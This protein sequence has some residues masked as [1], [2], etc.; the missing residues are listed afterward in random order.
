MRSAVLCHSTEDAALS[1]ELAGFLEL[2]CP[3]TVFQEEGLIRADYGLLDAV[4]RGLSAGVALVLL[5][6]DSVPNV[7]PPRE[8]W[9]PILLKQ[10]Y[11]FGSEI[12]CLLAR[13]CKFPALLRRGRNFFDLSQDRL[14]GRRALKRWLLGRDLLFQRAVELPEEGHPAGTDGEL[15]EKLRRHLAD[16]PGLESDIGREAAL[17]FAHSHKL[18]FEGLFWLNCAN[19]SR[20]GILG[21]I[22]HRLGLRLSGTVEQNRCALQN[23]RAGRRCL[24]IFEHV[25]PEDR[26]LATVQGKASV[27]FT[28]PAAMPSPCSL[29]ETSA[30]F[31]SWTQNLDL[32]LSAL[33]DAQHHLR[34]LPAS[35]GDSFEARMSLGSAAF[36][37]LKHCDRLAEA[38]EMLEMMSHAMRAKGDPLSLYR[39]E[40]EKSWFREAWDQ[41]LMP[42]S[43]PSPLSEPAQLSLEFARAGSRSS[44]IFGQ[45]CPR[46]RSFR[47]G[48]TAEK[49]ENHGN[50][51]EA[52]LPDRGAA[53]MGF[54]RDLR[55]A[56]RVLLRSRVAT[57]VAILALALGIGV[58]A[59]A[60]ISLE[61]IVLH[62]MPYP[63]LRRILTISSGASKDPAER[64]PLSAGE[65]TDLKK[66]SHSV[67]RL[68]GFRPWNAAITGAGNPEEVL[69]CL[70][71]P[72]FFS[73]FGMR[74]LLGR[75][76]VTDDGRADRAKVVVVSESFWKS[77][78]AGAPDAIGKMI[79]LGG[80]KY[81]VVGVM[82]DEFDFPLT[83]ELWAPLILDPAEQHDRTI[84][85]LNGVALLKANVTVAE[86]RA[87]ISAI[88]SRLGQRYPDTDGGR[89]LQVVPLRE[90]TEGVTNHFVVTLV[91][92]AAFVLLLACTNVA[93]LQLA[94]TASRQREIAVR[95][96]LGASRF[97]IARQLAAESV[98]ISVTGGL[99]GLILA[100]WSNDSAKVNIPPVAFRLVPGLR[101]MRVDST[102]IL[103][104]IALSL[105]AALI[106]ALPSV[107]QLLRRQTR[108]DLSDALRERGTGESYARSRVRSAL[109]VAELAL[110]L[111]LLVGAG[112]MV[113]TFQNLLNRYQGFDPKNV[114][115]MKVSL[116]AAKYT[117]DARIVR[118]FDRAL[119]ELGHIR[120]VEVASLGAT[121]GSDEHFLVEGRPEPRP[122]EP[123]PDVLSVGS[124]YLNAMRI[125][126]YSGRF[127]SERDRPQSPRV[128][129]VSQSV[130]RHYWP[131]AN[132]V[133]S[134]TKLEK[135]GEWLTVVGVTADVINDWFTGEHALTAYVPYTQAPPLS[136]SLYLRT[137]GDP[138]QAASPARSAIQRLD[139][140]LPVYDVQ[141]MEEATSQERGGVR[142]AASLMTQYATIALLLAITGVYGVISYAVAGRTHEIG[143]RMAVGATSSDMLKM[144]MLET[145]RLVALG[146]AF[147]LPLAVLL[148]KLMS[149]AL[150]GVVAINWITFATFALVLVG[151]ALLAGYLPS[152]RASR[153]DPMTALRDE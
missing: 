43:V 76:L 114:L 41:P 38:Y 107:V 65:F 18:D 148:A 81:T 122:D 130:V 22:S 4:E 61:S 16:Q 33:G 106:C 64:G 55:Y 6:P 117:K 66:Q 78:L 116:P 8:E 80:E 133:G 69:G 97:Q 44:P 131:H 37:L 105:I 13:E 96:A 138:L 15:F 86:S 102:V 95:A 32:C 145:A 127:I 137:S 126:L 23:F 101:H 94:R 1:G 36:T 12:V 120:G 48:A 93:N 151:A 87:E 73:V 47:P 31:F 113:D 92:A 56:A 63:N 100:S 71:A 30:L 35:K 39:L 128:I 91:G 57:V 152:W 104:T 129:V 141:T 103:L 29:E 136:A 45:G 134:R 142:A 90:L 115:T 49:R 121:H 68:A 59:T 112:L 146:L 7:W 19:R 51:V 67:E 5:S 85:N 125:P 89:S 144:T 2:N 24:F 50:A 27:I 110:A 75:P 10:P 143:V 42:P 70:V 123:A 119:E 98:L 53:M 139:K 124:G 132:P 77:H 140:D 3:V 52:Q 54:L 46:I 28:A 82:P 14:N 74:A 26:E 109:V 40:W 153:I 88:A 118:F 108:A 99:I 58:N 72:E 25:A 135:N 62:P 21:D 84:R 111:V 83:T 149:T 17:A 34:G 11:E 147:G 150:F 60:F 9:E 20:A 79:S